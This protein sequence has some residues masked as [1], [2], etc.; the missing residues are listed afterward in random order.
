MRPS[1]Y[2]YQTMDS[3]NVSLALPNTIYTN[4]GES[5]PPDIDTSPPLDIQG[6]KINQFM[7]GL[8]QM[9]VLL[10]CLDIATALM[11]LSSSIA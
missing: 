3:Y 9:I 11:T 2:I 10:G 7:I 8:P 1:K 6:I 4:F 5:R